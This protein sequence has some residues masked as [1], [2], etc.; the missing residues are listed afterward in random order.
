M[1][2]A[3]LIPARGL[4][5]GAFLLPSTTAPLGPSEGGPPQAG[6]LAETAAGTVLLVVVPP[7]SRSRVSD[8]TALPVTIHAD[9]WPTHLHWD[10]SSKRL[11]KPLIE[12]AHKTS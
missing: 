12:A 10:E 2:V 7:E 3:V 9:E 1:P 6:P 8:P 5:A 4:G 11:V